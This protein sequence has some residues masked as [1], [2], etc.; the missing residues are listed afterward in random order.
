MAD[1]YNERYSTLVDYHY[2]QFLSQMLFSIQ[3]PFH[4][5]RYGWYTELQHLL[6]GI[7]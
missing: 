6:I 1:L 5:N 3:T 4:L 7:L 2:G